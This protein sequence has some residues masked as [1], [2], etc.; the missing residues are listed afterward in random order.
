MA[1]QKT[2]RSE[3]RGV[4][5]VAAINGLVKTEWLVAGVVLRGPGHAFS[6]PSKVELQREL[7]LP[8]VVLE[9]AGG[10]DLPEG[11]RIF[12][13]YAAA[14]LFMNGSNWLMQR[15]RMRIP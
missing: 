12:V 8:L 7:A 13:N 9:V 3:Q 1:E 2:A 4:Q 15:G 11:G 10:R 5:E 6:S 14:A